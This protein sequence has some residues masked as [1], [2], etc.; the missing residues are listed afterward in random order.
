VVPG[1][2]TVRE[3]HARLDRIERDIGAAVPDALVETDL[4]PADDPTESRD[5]RDYRS[6][7]SVRA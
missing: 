4:E 5:L 7:G 6:P 3:G 2:W 1:D